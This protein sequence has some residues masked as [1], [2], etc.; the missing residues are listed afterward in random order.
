MFQNSPIRCQVP[1]EFGTAARTRTTTNPAS[2]IQL[3]VRAGGEVGYQTNS[4]RFA[5][6]FTDAP[7]HTAADGT[8][9]GITVA[10]NGNAI[11]NG[12][13]VVIPHPRMH[14]RLFVLRPLAEIAPNA[15]H[16]VLHRTMAQLLAEAESRQ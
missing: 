11:I 9:Q 2:E 14:E 10:N 3:A 5:V 8:A 7:F 16:P 13:P 6:L 12:G 1:Q 15:V 4:A